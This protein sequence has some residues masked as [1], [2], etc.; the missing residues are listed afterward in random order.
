MD[1]FECINAI[2]K[3]FVMLMTADSTC[4]WFIVRHYRFRLHMHCS[5]YVVCLHDISSAG[6]YRNNCRLLYA[7]RTLHSANV[8]CDKMLKCL[9]IIRRKCVIWSHLLYSKHYTLKHTFINYIYFAQD[10][11]I[12]DKKNNIKIEFNFSNWKKKTFQSDVQGR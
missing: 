1:R 6:N 5:L 7:Q 8:P 3:H 4:L 10:L 9:F 11:F 2:V 12:F